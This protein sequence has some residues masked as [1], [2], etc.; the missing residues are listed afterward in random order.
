M[1]KMQISGKSEYAKKNANYASCI[2]S[3]SLLSVP[4]EN[5]NLGDVSKSGAQLRKYI[6][7]MAPIAVFSKI[8][9]PSCLPAGGGGMH[10]SHPN[11]P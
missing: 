9:I 10:T 1:Q 3:P 7:L 8:V 5:M 6:W 11:V 2:F 4:K